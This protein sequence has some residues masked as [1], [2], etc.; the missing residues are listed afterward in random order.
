MIFGNKFIAMISS[1]IE[2]VS[3]I[4]WMYQLNFLLELEIAIMLLN[5]KLLKVKSK[6]LLIATGMDLLCFNQLTDRKMVLLSMLSHHSELI[7]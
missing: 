4:V 2:W 7:L 6:L 3:I 1:G 5:V